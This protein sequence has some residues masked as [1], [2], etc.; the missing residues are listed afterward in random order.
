MLDPVVL[1]SFLAVAR[2]QGFSEAARGLGLGQPTVSQHVRRLE[3][4]VRRRLFVRDTHSVSLTPDGS[5]MLALAQGILEAHERAEQYFSAAQLR[6]RLRF[7]AS[8]DFVFSRLPDV[9]REF[10]HS[11]PILD[12]ELTVGSSSGLNTMLDEG[13]LDL[14]L[15]KRPPGDDRGH[16]VWRDPMVWVGAPGAAVDEHQPV[17]LII[18]PAPSVTRDHVLRALERQGRA[19]RIACTSRSLTGLRAAALAELGVLALARAPIPVGLAEL[20]ATRTLPALGD[21]EF[22]LRA[23]GGA[24]RPPALQLADAILANGGRLLPDRRAV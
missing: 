2:A 16:L 23:A 4:Q 22:V 9:L 1:R 3:Q 14:V 7:G 17:P 15:A 21:A 5:A 19:W 11:H 8:E 18:Y 13:E 6:G 24:L 12:L 20:A 10:R